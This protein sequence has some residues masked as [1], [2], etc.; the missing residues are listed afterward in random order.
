MAV[1]GCSTYWHWRRRGG[2]SGKWVPRRSLGTRKPRSRGGSPGAH[3]KSRGGSEVRGGSWEMANVIQ[4]R[5]Q[6][7][8][9]E[10][11]AEGLG[12]FTAGFDD[13]FLNLDADRAA[14]GAGL[15]DDADPVAA[16]LLQRRQN[17][18]DDRIVIDRFVELQNR[19]QGNVELE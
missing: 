8:G 11:G 12:G 6:R 5:L 17:A 18:G 7:V 13:A 14:A 1:F 4:Q 10:A 15:A 2:A 19:H 16:A 3:K 9:I